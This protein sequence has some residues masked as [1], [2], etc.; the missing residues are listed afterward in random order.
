MENRTANL[1]PMHFVI[2]LAT[3]L[4]LWQEQGEAAS[5]SVR[6]D[7]GPIER[8]GPGDTLPVRVGTRVLL[9]ADYDCVWEWRIENMNSQALT[10]ETTGM[11][12][13]LH[14]VPFTREEM[15][16]YS[17]DYYGT[18]RNL[19][20]VAVGSNLFRT[21]GGHSTDGVR[22]N[23]VVLASAQGQVDIQISCVQS[24]RLK[25]T[26]GYWQA[27][28]GSNVIDTG[29]VYVREEAGRGE[30]VLHVQG[31]NGS[32]VPEGVYICTTDEG[33]SYRVLLYRD[34]YS[35]V[36]GSGERELLAAGSE[37]L[38]VSI[39]E[40]IS[41]VCPKDSIPDYLGEYCRQIRSV[42]TLRTLTRG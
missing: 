25:H 23:S 21:Y 6:V 8:Y 34:V 28:D 35:V 37:T 30:A 40:E 27:P 14:I 42:Q 36:R 1:N 26:G 3:C 31:S 4:C 22:N 12:R 41:L 38:Y 2:L 16:V 24:G 39:G 13:L 29:N 7:S 15:G 9:I 18:A 19:T 32:N 33:D 11:L 17:C 20:L 5:L 10:A